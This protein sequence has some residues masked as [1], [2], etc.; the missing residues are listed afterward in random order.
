MNVS[1]L[2][3]EAIVITNIVV[4]VPLLPECAAAAQRLAAPNKRNFERL[5]GGCENINLRF[6]DQQV[7]VLWHYHVSVD[8]GPI[9]AARPFQTF[10]KDVS[11]PRIR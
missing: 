7:N 1:Q 4:V 5:N 10:E 8:A 6:R 2:L 9:Y 11:K 3:F